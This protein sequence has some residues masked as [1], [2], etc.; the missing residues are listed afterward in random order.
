MNPIIQGV[1]NLKELFYDTNK[2]VSFLFSDGAM[3][4]LFIFLCWVVVAAW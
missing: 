3:I 1:D 2:I 4:P